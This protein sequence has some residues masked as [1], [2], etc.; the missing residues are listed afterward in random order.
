LEA[1]HAIR[2]DVAVLPST[3]TDQYLVWMAVLEEDMDSFRPEFV[4]YNAGTDILEGDPLGNLSITAEGI[5]IRDE[6]M[7]QMC[8]DRKIPVAMFLSGGYQKVNAE[9]IAN[10]IQNLLQKFG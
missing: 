1:A 4:I 3:T 6:M 5:I 8:V 2:R 10:S 7:I 9:I